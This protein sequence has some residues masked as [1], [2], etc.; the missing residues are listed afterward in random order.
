MRVRKDEK[1]VGE[2]PRFGGSALA[3]AARRDFEVLRER[4]VEASAST[5]LVG[6][7]TL[8]DFWR[9]HVIDCGQLLDF[10]PRALTWADIGSGA[11][12]P[13]VVVAILL[14]GRPGAHVR[15]VESRAKPCAF[16]REI[17][18]ALALPAE[19]V[20]GRAETMTDPVEVVT[21]RACAPLDRL[22]ELARGF[23]VSGAR[24]LF[25]KGETAEAEVAKARRRWRFDCEMIRAAAIR[26]ATCSP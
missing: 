13:G 17:V 9:R 11:G 2:E 12:F 26:A 7:S 19:V 23:F 3:P 14:K 1:F 24:G 18:A 6:R 10:A 8:P 16:L 21:A 15:L 20:E 4:L 25:L 22:L 5:N